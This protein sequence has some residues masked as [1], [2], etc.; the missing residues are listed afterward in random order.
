MHQ[1][2]CSAPLSIFG[3]R[4]KPALKQAAAARVEGLLLDTRNMVTPAEFSASAIRHLR[5]HL[6]ELGLVLAAT[7]FPT[8]RGFSDRRDLQPRVEAACKA[9]TF[10][11]ALGTD[12]LTLNI[13][14]VPP[15]ETDEA[16]R[17]DRDLLVEVLNDLARHGN[18][19]GAVP[20]I[21]VSASDLV[22]FQSLLASIDAGPIGVDFDPASWS[23]RG[24]NPAEAFRELYAVVRHVWARDA[25]RASD[26]S[27]R[28]VQVGRGEVAWDEMLAVLA[29]AE[30]NGWLTVGACGTDDPVG[31]TA[32]SVS[33]LRS[34]ATG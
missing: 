3:S 14:P 6:E 27:Y 5:K 11:R 4:L 20:V 12:V 23:G 7:S 1:F 28:E 31:D 2:R 8:R 33:M 29:E 18:H 17:N 22:T 13:G 10:A 9:L 26:G 21:G 16:G 32:R 15:D 30:Y 25:V 19:V 34:I 24:L